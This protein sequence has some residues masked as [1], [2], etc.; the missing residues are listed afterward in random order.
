MVTARAARAIQERICDGWTSVF[1]R[2]RSTSIVAP[3]IDRTCVTP[4][5]RSE[6][7][8]NGTVG[9]LPCSSPAKL[10]GANSAKNAITNGDHLAIAISSSTTA[11]SFYPDIQN[12]DKDRRLDQIAHINRQISSIQAIIASGASPFIS[13]T[14]TNESSTFP[15]FE[16]MKVA[17]TGN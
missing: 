14:S 6:L 1:P 4:L 11:F 13:S 5:V 2:A 17:G 7:L 3:P 8:E 9:S 10:Q 16:T 15:S 12:G